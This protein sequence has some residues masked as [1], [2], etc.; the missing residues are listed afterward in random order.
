MT[1]SLSL[2]DFMRLHVEALFTHDDAGRLLAV[3]E[4]GG[5][6]APRFFLGR[7]A[8]GDAWWFRRDVGAALVSDLETLCEALPAGLDI[9]PAPFV[10][11]LGRDEPVQKVWAGP[12]YRFP[13]T[14]AA[15]EGTVRVTADNAALLSPHLEAWL[16]D[17]AAGMPM[18]V[19]L[20]GEKAVAVCGSVRMTRE[21]H[22]AGVET[23]RDS[24]G[25]GYGARAVKAW[26]RVV[27]EMDRVPLYSTS[28][29]NG[30]SRGLASRLELIHFGN[31]LHIT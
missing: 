9:D 31:D 18:A 8:D 4:P 10:E 23:H 14:P 15:D 25:R 27:R 7:T 28:W 3:N 13:E 6:A 11:R 20:A 21:A 2:W 12:A 24:R 16:G 19:A 30:G 5:A 1:V 22:E 29:E 17:V 26:A